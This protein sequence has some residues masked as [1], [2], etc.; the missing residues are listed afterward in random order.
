LAPWRP[1]FHTNRNG[2]NNSATNPFGYAQPPA[3]P[4]AG[5]YSPATGDKAKG[6]FFD[7]KPERVVNG[8]FL[9]PYGTPYIF[10]GSKNGNDYDAFG[11]Y[12]GG[13]IPGFMVDGGWGGVS[14]FKGLDGKYINPNGFQIISAGKN[15]QFGP[16]G[17]FDPGVNNYSPGAPGGDDL[18]NFYRSVLGGSN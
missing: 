16:G 12:A 4:A 15:K 7:F 9:D 14:P 2:F 13:V 3:A 8:Q 5:W 6:P 17:A 18:S 11:I 1:V 10:F